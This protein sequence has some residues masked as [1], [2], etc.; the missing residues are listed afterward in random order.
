VTGGDVEVAIIGWKN[1]AKFFG[2]SE[3]SMLRH[4][5]EL[6]EAGYIFYINLGRPPRRKVAA[7]PSQ[8]MSW[9]A[10]RGSL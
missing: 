5:Q 7:F 3:R 1:I 9:M 2:V 6:K 10:L 4:K 8:L